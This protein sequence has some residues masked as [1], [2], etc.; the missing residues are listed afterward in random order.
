MA[1]FRLEN[2]RYKDVLGIETLSIDEKRVTCL[3]GKS[4]G[5]K[6][7]L[8][9]LLNKMISPD[10]G[11]IFYRDESLASID[12]VM[13]RRRVVLLHQKPFVFSGSIRDNL[14]KPLSFRR[15]QVDDDALKDALTRVSLDK[16]LDTNASTL[17]GGEAQRLALARLMLLDV[18]CVLLDEPSSALDE[19]TERDVIQAVVK[20]VKSRG[21]TLVMITHSTAIAKEYGDIVYTMTDG[22]VKE[23]S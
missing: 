7:T 3:V 13:H 10:S 19:A 9:R 6:T 23:A 5:G 18:E 4:G 17:S 8:L 2:I 15:E 14:L 16:S 21:L 20:F 11:D 22:R 1:L 12:S